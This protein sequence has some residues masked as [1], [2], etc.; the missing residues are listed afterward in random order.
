MAST[1]VMAPHL[2]VAAP[3][4]WVLIRL[5]LCLSCLSQWEFS[6][7]PELCEIFSIGLQ[8][9]EI[10]VLYVV[11]VLACLWEG[12]SSGPSNSAILTLSLV[13]NSLHEILTVAVIGV[14]SVSCLDFDQCSR[15]GI[16]PKILHF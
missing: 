6:L 8:F 13:N 1:I 3:A 7:Y 15:S 2:Y 14:V 4:V 10:A 12:V 16:E 5:C 9:S 11:V